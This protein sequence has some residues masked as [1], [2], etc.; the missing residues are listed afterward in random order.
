MDIFFLHL[1][2]IRLPLGRAVAEL[3]EIQHLHSKPQRKGGP[4]DPKMHRTCETCLLIQN[5]DET[6]GNLVVMVQVVQK[7]RETG[8]VSIIKYKIRGLTQ[9]S[10]TMFV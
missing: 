10:H 1:S 8:N 3:L 4:S 7:M 6:H 2:L 5:F 9:L